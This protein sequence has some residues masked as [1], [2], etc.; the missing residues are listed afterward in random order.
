[1]PATG[2]VI[3]TTALDST[4]TRLVPF[5]NGISGL[6]WNCSEVMLRA[7]KTPSS[8]ICRIPLS[9][10][11]DET[12]P[13]VAMVRSGPHDNI[14]TGTPTS[15]YG[16][17]GG[18]PV[19]LMNGLVVNLRHD[20][21][22]DTLVAEVLD[23]RYLLEGLTF[24]GSFW[25]KPSDAG[26]TYRQGWHAHFNQ[27]GAPNMTYSALGS[28]PG[29]Y[30]PVFC[31]P[32]YGL[33][34]DE[35]VPG[36][37]DTGVQSGTKASYWRLEDIFT[38][39][40]FVF[41]S[42]V[43]S[44][45]DDF[46]GYA[47]LPDRI[48]WPTALSSGISADD[49]TAG[50]A[51]SVGRTAK[52]PEMVFEGLSLLAALTE[53]CNRAGN[54]ALDM[55]PMQEGQS[56]LAIVKTRYAGQGITLNRPTTGAASEALQS[57]NIVTSGGY[58]ESIRNTYTKVSIG[59]ALVY[60]EK[61]LASTGTTGQYGL[62]P[63]WSADLQSELKAEIEADLNGGDPAYATAKLAFEGLLQKPKYYKIC[64]AWRIAP[65]Y[66]Y[67]S[68]TSET[69][70]PIAEIGRPILPAQLTSYLEGLAGSTSNTDRYSTRCPLYVEYSL[71]ATTDTDG[72]WTLA[73]EHVPQAI[74]ADGTIWITA[75][76]SLA[77]SYEITQSGSS[78]NISVTINVARIRMNVAIPAD[79]RLEKTYSMPQDTS[80]GQ[81]LTADFPDAER[82]DSAL[83]RNYS[84]A[85]EQLYRYELR[86][87]GSYPTPA[88]RDGE[89]PG[90]KVLADD[91]AYLNALVARR[92]LDLGRVQR[93]GRL[94]MPHHVFSLRPGAQIKSVQNSSGGDF[95]IRG[96]V[97]A[98]RYESGDVNLT[99]LQIR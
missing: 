97:D 57:F 6:H 15:L 18:T 4:A 46:P 17:F 72:S 88:T 22:A 85:A 44:L 38:Y 67:Q 90:A 40:R 43:S 3:S 63:A 65:D 59:G 48:I 89:A 98:V 34:P 9:A 19:L 32:Y 82:I 74:D 23:D 28:G 64:A 54:Y 26:A 78:P 62:K 83:S 81:T 56:Q 99:E 7:G 41:S 92:L 14:K 2:K 61:R 31:P 87:S 11:I 69:G 93:E 29:N 51:A 12:A 71:D 47:F 33:A 20:L 94:I 79:H 53:L 1:M 42:A 91:T 80:G 58:E 49:F 8:A 77:Q 24:R 10:A 35:E 39:A 45:V 50:N 36:S 37:S 60:I 86:T 52:G 55:L 27:R 66:D 76:R 75:L 95:P 25:I 70:Y 5:F 96:I 30:F 13:S 21:N 16:Y 73:T 84:A 68:G